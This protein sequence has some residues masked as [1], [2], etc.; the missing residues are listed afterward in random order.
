MKRILIIEDDQIVGTIYRR[1]FQLEGFEVALAAD[2]ETGLG[3]VATFHP[4]LVILDLMLPRLNGV[5]VLRRIRAQPENQ[6][7]PVIVLSNAY[8]SNLV[9]DATSAG[10]NQCLI[11]ANCTPKQI[12]EVIRKTL[13]ED[14]GYIVNW[15]IVDAARWV[16]QSRKRI[17]LV[18]YNP[19]RIKITREEIVIPTQPGPS[20][21]Y[22]EL[23]RIVDRFA[24]KRYMLGPG[25]WATLER[26][27]KHHAEAGNGFGYGLHTFPI[28]DGTVTRTI[29]ARYHKDGAEVLV[30]TDGPRPRKLTVEEAAQLHLIYRLLPHYP[31]QPLRNSVAVPAVAA[32]ARQIA[33]ILKDRL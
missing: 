7:L 20:Y 1:K 24:D 15:Q 5:E 2:G 9:Q 11:K 6:K 22:P 14:L 10:A 12:L 17:F 25:T 8:L 18:G 30:Q 19:E 3:A 21:R 23:N 4:D 33:D 26:H 28:P 31:E 27:K 16:P 13:E 29:S 32:S